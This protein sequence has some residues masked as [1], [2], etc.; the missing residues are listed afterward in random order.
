MKQ[1]IFRP[2]GKTNIS[3]ALRTF[4]TIGASNI[5]G[6]QWKRENMYF[7]AEILSQKEL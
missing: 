7:R 1:S 3:M 6:D 2:D 4:V 5:L